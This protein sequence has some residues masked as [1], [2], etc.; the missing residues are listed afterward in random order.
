MIGICDGDVN[1]GPE[2][3]LAELIADAGFDITEFDED[4]TLSDPLCLAPLYSSL[5]RCFVPSMVDHSLSCGA[6]GVSPS[7]GNAEST[8][9]SFSVF[10]KA[11]TTTGGLSAISVKHR[12]S[13]KQ[14]TAACSDI[15]FP[16]CFH[17]SDS[18]QCIGHFSVSPDSFETRLSPEF[19]VGIPT[20]VEE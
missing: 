7:T 14:L 1:G 4:G 6:L 20:H 19:S 15:S 9:D 16:N 8:S 17:L 11:C 5:G 13:K 3:S 12:R 10:T 18:M 2:V